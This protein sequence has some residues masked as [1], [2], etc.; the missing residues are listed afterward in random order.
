MITLYQ[1]PRPRTVPTY[2][3]FCLK[4][5][6]YMRWAGVP[7]QNKFSFKTKGS[8]TGKMPYIED[9]GVVYTDSSLIIE[10]LKKQNP[11]WDLDARLTAEQ[12]ALAT[13]I[14]GV[15]E[16]RVVR[17]SV[18]LRWADP[19]GWAE[20][21]KII[22]YGVPAPIAFLVGK[23]LH[24]TQKANSWSHGVGRFKREEVIGFLDRDLESLE[25]LIGTKK[26]FFGD[27]PTSV[28]AILFGALIQFT[29]A[30]IP[31]A[32]KNLGERRPLLKAYVDRCLASFNERAPKS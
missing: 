20:F 12:H 17:F 27:E 22:L 14:Q 29:H 13:V 19:E 18:H 9:G 1:Y 10:R 21:K 7:Y 23:K 11:A 2:S 8:P 15:V 30:G 3:P 24:G 16:D 5:E 4:L 25:T 28:D 32:M 26:F 31:R 6:A